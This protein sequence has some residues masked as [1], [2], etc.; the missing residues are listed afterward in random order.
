MKFFIFLIFIYPRIEVFPRV[1]EAGRVFEGS[2][3]HPEFKIK[4]KGDK[5]LEIV[6]VKTCCGIK[7]FIEKIK[8]P[9]RDS[10]FLRFEIILE[11][12][13]EYEDE[14][15]LITNDP[16]EPNIRLKIKAN[17]LRIPKPL[18]ETEE[19]IDIGDIFLGEKKDT[20]INVYNKGDA[21]L[22]LLEGEGSSTCEIISKFPITINPGKKEIIKIEINPLK[23]G[24][25]EEE[26]RIAT[27]IKGKLFHFVKII[28]NAKGSKLFF[29][30]PIYLK[31]DTLF[32][33]NSGNGEI[34]IKEIKIKGKILMKNKILKSK[35]EIKIILEEVPK[36][37][38]IEID[39]K[40]PYILH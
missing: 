23:E 40:I 5:V 32:L 24:I 35:E 30:S 18:I 22:I 20:F 16:Y 7:A 39:F 19:I 11:K 3:I 17:V 27:N 1:F 29:P 38:D 25:F 28:G 33:K 10:S 9:P 15:L 37:G 8:I 34:F 4:N 14:A 36:K 26:I 2:I 12:E 13:G 21:D 6:D 31:N